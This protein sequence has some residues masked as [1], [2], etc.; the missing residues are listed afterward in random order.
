MNNWKIFTLCIITLSLASCS[1]SKTSVNSQSKASVTSSSAGGGSVTSYPKSNSTQQ[2]I[3]KYKQIAVEEM[4]RTGI[5]ASI[6]LA[7]GIFESASG[8][9]DLAIK[10]NNHF[11]VKCTSDWNGETYHKDDDKPNE[12]FRKYPHAEGSFHDHSQFLQRPRYASL[13]KL[14]PAD[15]KGWANGLKAAGYA[16]NPQYGPKLIELIE[17][18]ELNKFDKAGQK[19]MVVAS[20]NRGSLYFEQKPVNEEGY[21]KKQPQFLQ[22][23]KKWYRKAFTELKQEILYTVSLKNLM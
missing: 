19:D 14:D 9:S 2:Y 6:T 3:N 15:Y 22:L 7:Q 20:T 1:A 23:L 18:Y 11:G 5:P 17:R 12:C 16:T 8:N 10:A 13:F 4:R 21:V